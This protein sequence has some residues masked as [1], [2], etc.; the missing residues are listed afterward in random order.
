MWTI[1]KNRENLV[2]RLFLEKKLWIVCVS[3]YLASLTDFE[4]WVCETRVL[5]Q[6]SNYNGVFF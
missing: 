2:F 5:A 3:N 1:Y 4:T 6:N